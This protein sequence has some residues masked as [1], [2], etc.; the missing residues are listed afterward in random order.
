MDSAAGNDLFTAL[1]RARSGGFILDSPDDL[2]KFGFDAPAASFEVRSGDDVQRLLVGGRMGVGVEDR[3][4]IV[5]GRP[6]VVR[7]PAAVLRTLFR[8]AAEL[9]DRTA[10]GVPAADVKS[11]VIRSHGGELTLT[12]DLDRWKTG[13]VFVETRPVEVLLDRLT[14]QRAIAVEI[15]PYPRADEVATITLLG[16]GGRPLDTVRVARDPR[17]GQWVLD[18]GDNVLRLHPAETHLPL[19]SAD[20]GLTP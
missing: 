19:A 18:N 12:R 4:G 2:S 8:P 9:I 16:F 20:F 14:T 3:F 11:L 1:G 13:D 17:S 6:V 15:Q 5:E 7:L 10:S